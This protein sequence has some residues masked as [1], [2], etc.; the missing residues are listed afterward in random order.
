[1]ASS[2]ASCRSRPSCSP[3]GSRKAG[4]QPGGIRP[5]GRDRHQGSRKH[6]REQKRARSSRRFIVLA[7]RRALGIGG[8]RL[9]RNSSARPGLVH[10]PSQEPCCPRALSS[11]PDPSPIDAWPR[12]PSFLG[13]IPD[14][15]GRPG[16]PE[17]LAMLSGGGGLQGTFRPASRRPDPAFRSGSAGSQGKWLDGMPHPPG[18]PSPPSGTPHR[19]LPSLCSRTARPS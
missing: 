16:N 17:A 19:A 2:I 7:V 11:S 14:P 12:I 6:G 15:A 5:R 18:S 3:R 8:Y 10:P 1:M 13:R 4:L 9:A